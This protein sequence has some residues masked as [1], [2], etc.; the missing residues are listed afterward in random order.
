MVIAAI[1]PILAE[2]LID[3]IQMEKAGS[4]YSRDLYHNIDSQFAEERTFMTGF[5]VWNNVG[6]AFRCFALGAFFGIGTVV[7]L[8]FNGLTLGAVT[9]YLVNKGYADNFFS[10]AISHGSFELTAIVIAGAAGLLLGWGMIH[11]GEVS[12][13][14]SLRAHG[15]DAIKLA[16]GAGFMLLIAALI[17]G[18]FSPIALPHLVKYVVGTMLWVLVYVYLVNGGRDG[19]EVRSV[20]EH[21]NA[22]TMEVSA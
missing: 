18:Y 17:E 7:T 9:G 14:E 2:Q 10:F 15:L 1:D 20:D 11:P 8:L 4:S 21:R 13:L 16:T 22:E 12:R 5:Y 3:K 6:I 19:I